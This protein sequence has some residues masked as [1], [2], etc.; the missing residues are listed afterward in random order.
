MA[1]SG[2]SGKLA[3]LWQVPLLLLS[4]GL[5]GY[6]TYLFIDPKPG[7]SI[8]QKIDLARSYL[9]YS[10]P[11]AAIEQCNNLLAGEQLLRE[12]EGKI[13]LLLAEALE[14]GQK[15]NHVDIAANHRR[16]IEQTEVALAQGVKPE[17][18]IYRRLG[19]SYEA[20]KL[21][22]KALE[23][24]RHAM[25]MDTNRALHLQ[26]RVIDLQLTQDDTGPALATLEE[27]LKDQKLTN[28]E[29]GW[30]L[31]EKAQVLAERGSF[32]ESRALLGEALRLNS[33]PVSQGE[34]NYRL[35][36]AAWK[37]GGLA[38]AERC[39]RVARD[40]LR[41]QHPL[42]ADAAYLLGKIRRDANDAK[43]AMS[44]FQSVLVSHPGAR[45]AP[46]ARLGRATCRV[47]LGEDEAALT[48]LHDVVGE[49]G[50]KPSRQKWKRETIDAL[51]QVS[52]TLA[53]RGNYQGAMETLAY[54]QTLEPK[55][56]PEFYGRLAAVYEKRAD[57]IERSSETA[58]DAAQKI[59]RGQQ[60]RDLRT[61]AGDAY[62]AYSRALTVEDDKG[63]GE[64]LWKGV[65]LYDRA[66]NMQAAISALE[67]FVAERPQDGKAPDALLRLGRSHQA[68]GQFDKAIS[69]FQRNQF[70]Y[71]QS[72]AAS[73]S[74]VPLAQAYIAKGP[75]SYGK[76]EATLKAVVEDNPLITPD[77]MEFRQALFELAQLYYRTNRYEE[78]VSRLEEL[79]QRYPKDDRMGQLVFLMADSYRKSAAL[80]TEARLASSNPKDTGN[81]ADQ[82]EAA[83]AKNDRL[84][85]A[86]KLYDQ[87]ID[88]YRQSPPT[89]E[90]DKLYHKL[91]HFYRADCHYDLGDFQEAI[92]L[93]D[94]ATLR[95]QDDPSALAAYV[96]IVNSYCALGKTSEAKAANERAKWLLRRMPRE[97]F[98][99][100]KFSM[101]K[102]YWDEWLKW[103]STAGMF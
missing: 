41:T 1:S 12:N 51:R 50:E 65:D 102:E 62:I 3:H 26:R 38:E 79:T 74:G 8:E 93:Y 17:A 66:G 70:R 40:Q 14:A 6:A 94:A 72:L 63:H 54:E 55:P 9:R 34:V 20:L 44:F 23:S 46:L 22:G 11:D 85:K 36:Y 27:Y 19:E 4:L 24:F 90:L 86:M 73:Q 33:D 59:R 30:A 5:F 7:L 78:A 67:L 37:L 97:A 42:D 28:G 13:H 57:Q 69:I 98:Q 39:L 100:G 88:M 56:G 43:E 18:D 91:S 82:A 87:V 95:Y 32:I 71:P 15:E 64:A 52:G 92:K 60:I 53:S 77:A 76:A 81:A 101:P 45:V 10:R 83:A 96:Q 48:D 75:Q 58:A 31:G 29:R 21:P 35:G 47:T 68:S 103:T 80:L 61:K 16:I 49:I 25:A 89:E 84:T 99:D 2:A